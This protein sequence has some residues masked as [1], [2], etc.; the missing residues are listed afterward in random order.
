MPE[1]IQE[2]KKSI[3]KTIAE[4]QAKM[5]LIEEKLASDRKSKRQKETQL[6]FGTKFKEVTIKEEDGDSSSGD[7]TPVQSARQ[8]QNTNI[9]R[10]DRKLNMNIL[11]NNKF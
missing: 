6:L 2:E 8:S 4:E 11:T 3:Q 10:L 7:S 9:V 1:K 5:K